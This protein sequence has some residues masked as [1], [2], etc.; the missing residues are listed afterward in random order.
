[1]ALVTVRELTPE[2]GNGYYSVCPSCSSK[3][4]EG[5]HIEIEGP[6]AWQRVTCANGHRWIEV[7]RL[8]RIEQEE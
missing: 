4:I 7:Y 1:M 3:E 2:Q 8:A 6:E 5:G